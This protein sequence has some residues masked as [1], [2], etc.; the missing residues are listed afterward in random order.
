MKVNEELE[1][2]FVN[3]FVFG[4]YVAAPVCLEPSRSCKDQQNPEDLDVKFGNH[5]FKMIPE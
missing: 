4:W 3:N 2:Q 5:K 1:T